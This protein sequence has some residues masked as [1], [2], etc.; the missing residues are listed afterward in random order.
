VTLYSWV[1]VAGAVSW[2]P[3]Q[4]A[5]A[6]SLGGQ[7]EISVAGIGLG[8]A[9]EATLAGS[10]PAPFAVEGTLHVVVKLP[11]PIPDLDETIRLAWTQ[12]GVPALADPFAGVS[13][14]HPL[15]SDT[16]TAATT[17]TG[18][19][20]VPL[21]CRPTVVFARSVRDDSGLGTASSHHPGPTAVGDYAIDHA[22]TAVS[23]EQWA[24]VDG[25]GGW[26]P[27]EVELSAVWQLVENEGG[28]LVDTRLVV[29]GDTP[30]DFTRSSSETYSTGLLGAHS[31]EPCGTP[32]APD[33][34]CVNAAD[35][36]LDRVFE[37]G[38]STGLGDLLLPW[39]TRATTVPAAPGLGAAAF[40]IDTG[41]ES[42][43]E[44]TLWVRPA[45]AF[46][47]IAVLTRAVL[48]DVIVRVWRDG[49]VLAEEVLPAAQVRFIGLDVDAGQW[50]EMSGTRFDVAE[51][52]VLTHASNAGAIALEARRSALTRLTEQWG[53]LRPVL[54]PQ[55]RY[56]LTVQTSGTRTGGPDEAQES[57]TSH[58]YFQTG[59]P[60]GAPAPWDAVP[61]E[62]GGAATAFPTGGALA[63]LAPYVEATVPEADAPAHYPAY[64]L[65]ALLGSAD[66]EAMFGGDLRVQVRDRNG[67]LVTGADGRPL[68]AWNAWGTRPTLGLASYQ[69]PYAEAATSCL[70]VPVPPLPAPTLSLAPD[71]LLDLTFD[72]PSALS[73]L[74]AVLDVAGSSWQVR[75]GAL[76]Q[77]GSARPGA[78]VSQARF[79]G[80]LAVEVDLTLTRGAVA[81]VLGYVDDASHHRVVLDAGAS[82]ARLE[83]VSA[84]AVSRLWSGDVVLPLGVP[85]GLRAQVEG[86]RVR[87]LVDD[88]LLLDGPLLP[89]LAAEPP[90]DTAVGI[91]TWG[92]V[93]VA[94]DRL[95]VTRWPGGVLATSSRYDVELVGACLLAQAAALDPLPP[96]WQQDGEL[97]LVGLAQAWTDVRVQ[98]DLGADAGTGPV[99]LVARHGPGG[100]H[101][102]LV[103]HPATGRRTLVVHSGGAAD[104]LWAD[105]GYHAGD[106]QSLTL[107]V[108]GDVAEVSV[109]GQR[110]AT[111]GLGGAVPGP[112][113]AGVQG[114]QDEGAHAENV[115]VW[116]APR[117][118]AHSW[119]LTT[120]SAPDLVHLLD[121]FTG[122]VYP[123]PVT[124]AAGFAAWVRHAR[125]ERQGDDDA[126]AS[127][128]QAARAA[129]P[130]DLPAAAAAA[131]EATD[132]RT[133]HA[134]ALYA[135]GV[136]LLGLGHRAR[137]PVVELS[138]LAAAS[139]AVQA[140]LLELPEPLAWER[141]RVAGS[142]P[143]AGGPPVVVWN[144][145]GTRAL[146]LPPSGTRWPAG[147]Y[148][149]DLVL[150]LDVGPET[151]TWQRAT[152]TRAEVG[153]LAFALP[154]AGA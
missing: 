143:G 40:R 101:V 102:R 99:A 65:G 135:E 136:G 39:P 60:P 112:G 50:L 103:L 64:D 49:E 151:P 100:D 84:S 82:Q 31:E 58:A 147:E 62:G 109:S 134:A 106:V 87:L 150:D 38:L 121:T 145:D 36:P 3:I 137:P 95:R 9:A 57:W 146:L 17:D 68:L 51:I 47:R 148:V 153:R 118:V 37:G 44:A 133:A 97:T 16:W 48:G 116:T 83:T 126:Q 74:V 61:A 131:R 73:D 71:L 23:L 113:L 93:D 41:Q 127:A 42:G 104:E 45:E 25:A 5:G 15:T 1:E 56:R 79:T 142:L 132:S 108:V 53:A 98:A 119:P 75:D 67:R 138:A 13:L 114:A 92:S 24:R 89:A 81:L 59:G 115:T 43:M 27:A 86:S 30:L 8:I 78:L 107:E 29:W 105:T 122:T 12:P 22:L 110:L 128:R 32:V 18:G 141:V 85:F 66:V 77:D 55:T 88:A 130:L 11:T 125:D 52:C 14:T 76:H 54:R 124:P 33:V 120:S 149:L 35:W 10:A 63:T 69:V 21:D 19:P 28:D 117:S 139:G 123:E 20:L 80:G 144:G 46:D 34:V 7:Y 94:V 4:L 2:Q 91:G 152:S 72:D 90:A 111:V 96:G 140:L 26:V 129:A 70:G 6:V 154:L